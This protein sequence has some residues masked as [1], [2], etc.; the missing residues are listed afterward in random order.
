MKKEK[1]KLRVEVERLSL[2]E[3]KVYNCR[4]HQEL[5][6]PSRQH[7]L[8]YCP[9]A[10]SIRGGG[11]SGVSYGEKKF[12]IRHKDNFMYITRIE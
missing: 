9:D 12:S 5:Y 4:E 2:F 7:K 10:A 6:F 8:N 1:P 3:E 11:K